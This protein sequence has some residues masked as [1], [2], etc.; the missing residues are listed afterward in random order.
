MNPPGLMVQCRKYGLGMLLVWTGILAAILAF[1]L[2]EYRNDTIKEATREA[3]DYHELN[4]QYRKW[5]ARIG[6]VYAPTDK[7]APNPH[8]VVP[9]REVTTD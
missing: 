4:L 7:V 6:G 1:I 9:D 8:L 5:G 2:H 3:R